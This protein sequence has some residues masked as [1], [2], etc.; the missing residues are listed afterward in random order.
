MRPRVLV[1]SYH[2]ANPL[3]PR[4]ARSQ[5]VAAALSRHADVR[6]IAGRPETGR[7]TWW[8]RARDRTLFELGTRWLIDPL[9]P[10][11]WKVLA[12]R[13]PEADL[14]LLIGYPFSALV[15]AARVLG[16]H[17]IPYVLD[18]SDPWSLVRSHGQS[19]T[20]RDRRNTTLE[21]RLWK[22]ASAGI[23][24]TTA[25]AR[26]VLGL[27]PALNVLV[28]PNGFADHRA[29]PATTRREPDDELRIGHFG[30]L[31]APRLE[32]KTFVRRLAESGLW[33]RVVFYQYG[34]DHYGELRGLPESVTVQ[35]RDPVPWPEVVGLAAAELD[36]ALVVGN[37]DARQ[38]P[39]KAIEYLTLPVPRLALTGGL[40]GDALAE[41][42]DGKPG[43]LMLR[44]D[45]PDAATHIWEHVRQSW[46]AEELA[47]PADESWACVA[48]EIASF[49]LQR[50]ALRA[51]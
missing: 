17:G 13:D 20:L 9:E 22:G 35:L 23:V 40:A 14:A 39:S 50:L 30:N 26:D 15:V 11:S 45:D 31:Y 10:W 19:P 25:Q 8:H 5:A 1:V 3:T 27:E 29:S 12:R 16:P 28:R 7:R 2:A 44:V 42:V 51:A 49:V 43:W 34:R 38:L 33:R 18:M 4:G 47:P 48:E 41:Y 36:I 24:T 32:I 21:R 46:T 37:K 6:I